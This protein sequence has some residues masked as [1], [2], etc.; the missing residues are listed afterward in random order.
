[1]SIQDNFSNE[2]INCMFVGR[3]FHVFGI[4]SLKALS[5]ITVLVFLVYEYTI[6]LEF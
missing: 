6:Y 1:M 3:A 4:A 5:L 2:S